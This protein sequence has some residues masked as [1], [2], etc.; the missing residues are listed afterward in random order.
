MSRY[1]VQGVILLCNGAEGKAYINKEVHL[2]LILHSSV[3]Y[4][5]VRNEIRFLV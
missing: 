3:L 1:D 4:S 5:S 2:F